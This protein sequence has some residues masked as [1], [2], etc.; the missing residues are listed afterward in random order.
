MLGAAEVRTD[1]ASGRRYYAG[2]SLW[3]DA[4]GP[5]PGGGKQA[6]IE[7]CRKRRFRD[8]SLSRVS[9]VAAM[10]IAVVRAD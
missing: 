10:I 9:C 7:E 2:V 4:P 1:K 5:P 6:V 3:L 8:I